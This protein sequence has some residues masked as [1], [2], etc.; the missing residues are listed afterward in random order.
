MTGTRALRP[1]L[2]HVAISVD[3]DLL[4]ESGRRALLDFFSGVFGWT[5]GDNST[6]QGNPLI[7]YTGELRQFIYLLPS[8]DDYLRTA[9][10]DHIGLEVE[11]LEELHELV[12][13]ARAY[14]E[15]DQRV[16]VSEVGETVTHGTTS[17]YTLT[18]VYI[19]Y[20]LPLQIELQ[21]LAVRTS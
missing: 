11:N 4:D 21:H 7:L 10:L 12:E 5:E 20:V 18:H 14:G 2:N 19:S 3:A 6:E 9:R 15:R 13:K 17:D 16:S 1:Y 8:S